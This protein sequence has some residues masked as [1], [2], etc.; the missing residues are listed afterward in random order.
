LRQLRQRGDDVGKALAKALAAMPGDEHHRPLPV[1]ERQRLVQLGAQ[2]CVGIDARGGQIERVD[3]GIAGHDHLAGER[4]RQQVR[5]RAV[6]GGEHEIAHHVD[7][8]AVHLLG[9]RLGEVAGAQARLYMA[10]G[11]AAVERGQRGGAGG[12]RIAV[13]QHAVGHLGGEHVVH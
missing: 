6:G 10:D 7:H 12:G 13:H 9:P 11:D 5:L 3:H 4:F 2:C 8:A 1:E